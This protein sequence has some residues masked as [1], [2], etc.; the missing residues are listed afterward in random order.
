MLSRSV[1]L[2]PPHTHTRP[3]LLISRALFSLV[4][5]VL[6]TEV[7]ALRRR[8]GPDR[9][10]EVL[11]RELAKAG[12]KQ[13]EVQQELEQQAMVERCKPC[14][15]CSALLISPHRKLTSICGAG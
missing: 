14:V 10:D 5:A 1:L 12:Q 2:P 8:Y 4:L 15:F 7:M 6:S 13:V 9:F 11:A 3:L